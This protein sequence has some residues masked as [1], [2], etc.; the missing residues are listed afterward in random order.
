MK[1]IQIVLEGGGTDRTDLDVAELDG[2][3]GLLGLH[4]GRYPGGDRAGAAGD[5]RLAGVAVWREV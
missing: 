3:L 1:E 4:V 2:G 5:A